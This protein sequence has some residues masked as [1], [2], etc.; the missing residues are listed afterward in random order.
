MAPKLYQGYP[1]IQGF[2]GKNHEDLKNN[3]DDYCRNLIEII[4]Q[5]LVDCSYCKGYGVIIDESL[6]KKDE[7]KWRN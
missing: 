6:M 5:P 3:I 7:A 1:I 4:N 2:R